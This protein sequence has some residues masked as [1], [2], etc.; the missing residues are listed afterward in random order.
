VGYQRSTLRLKFA[1]GDEFEGLEAEVERLSVDGLIELIMLADNADMSGVDRYKR[2]CEML[3]DNI[4][5]WN[6]DDR[7]GQPIEPTL[8]NVRGRDPLAVMALIKAWR[9]A[10]V[11]IP[12]PLSGPSSDGDQSLVASI[13]METSSPNPANSDEPAS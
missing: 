11:A 2:M 5:T 6:F 8:D 13:P 4:V 3:A 9:S 12:P 1:P 10:A 7:H